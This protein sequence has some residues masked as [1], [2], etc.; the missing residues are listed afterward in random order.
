MILELTRGRLKLR[1]KWHPTDDVIQIM[2]TM[3]LLL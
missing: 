2:Q 1:I 3:D